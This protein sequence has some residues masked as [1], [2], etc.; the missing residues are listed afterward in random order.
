MDNSL[1]QDMDLHMNMDDLDA[2]A[3]YWPPGVD[4]A[5]SLAWPFMPF[6][7]QLEGMSAPPDYFA[8]SGDGMVDLGSFIIRPELLP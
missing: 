5:E 7:S 1:G 8:T 2:T 4:P 3:T 6:L